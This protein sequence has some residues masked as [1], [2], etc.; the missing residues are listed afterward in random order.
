MEYS[1]L[2][3]GRRFPLR[4]KSTVYRS[5]VRPVMLYSSETWCLGEVGIS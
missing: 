2:L 4:L 1:D 5:N 3:Y